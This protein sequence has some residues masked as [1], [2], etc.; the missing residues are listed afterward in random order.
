MLAFLPQFI[1]PAG[2]PV[3]LQ[4]LVLGTIFSLCAVIGDTL[5]ALAAG[6]AGTRLRRRLASPGRLSWAAG[7]IYVGLGLAAALADRGTKA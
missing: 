7:A 3:W 5:F 2:G 4:T 6:T 1:D